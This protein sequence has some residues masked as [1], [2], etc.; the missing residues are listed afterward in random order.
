M[1]E[2]EL[3]STLQSVSAIATAIGVC[4]AATYYIMNLRMT[5]R[6]LKIN[7]T[8]NLLQYFSSEEGQRRW[9]ELMNM[10]WSSY[11]EFERKY[12]SD[13]NP[14]NFAKR[15]SYFMNLNAVGHF[16]KAGIIDRETVYNVSTV[17]ASWVWLK[18]KGFFEEHKRRYVGKDNYVGLEYLA[19]EMMRMKLERNPEY[20]FPLLFTEYIPDK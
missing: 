6:T 2:A 11:D 12:G 20:K 10:K 9:I 3:L 18:F 13:N 7:M 5:Q 15:S 8:N 19:D 17:N 1:V 14:D 4:I 16:L